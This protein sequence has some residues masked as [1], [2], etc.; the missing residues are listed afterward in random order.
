MNPRAAATPVLPVDGDDALDETQTHERRR[1]L[2]L[3]ASDAGALRIRH[4]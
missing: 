3:P 1:G 2:L 4:G